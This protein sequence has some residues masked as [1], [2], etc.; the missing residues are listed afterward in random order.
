MNLY[1]GHSLFGSEWPW[2]DLAGSDFRIVDCGHRF[3]RLCSGKF[4]ENH[5]FR[6]GRRSGGDKDGKEGFRLFVDVGTQ[7]LAW[8]RIERSMGSNPEKERNYRPLPMKP[9]D[10]IRVK[11]ALDGNA[12]VACVNDDV[13]LSTRMYDRRENTFGI[14]SDTVGSEFANVTLCVRQET[15]KEGVK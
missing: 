15:E 6:G 14:W 10:R 3:L 8:D 5:P 2:S 13:C 12:A 9:G 4:G 11:V 1:E 7:R